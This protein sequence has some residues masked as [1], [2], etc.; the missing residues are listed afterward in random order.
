M[1]LAE[2][3]KLGTVHSGLYDILKENSSFL[4]CSFVRITKI[5]YFFVIKIGCL[6]LCKQPIEFLYKDKSY[7]K[8]IQQMCFYRINK[9]LKAMLIHDW[10]NQQLYKTVGTIKYIVA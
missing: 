6:F 3:N 1:Y 4:G 10:V 9:Q 5:T 8:R 7:L 2:V